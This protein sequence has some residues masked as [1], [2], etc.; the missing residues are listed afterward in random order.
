LFA[1]LFAGGL[2]GF[3]GL[4]ASALFAGLLAA[5]VAGL[6]ALAGCDPALKLV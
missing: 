5:G 4:A 1:G 3:D 2:L 6:A